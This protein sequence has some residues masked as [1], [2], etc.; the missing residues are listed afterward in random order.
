VGWTWIALTASIGLTMALA[1]WWDVAGLPALPGLAFAFL[2]PNGD[3]LWREFQ[4]WRK[5]RK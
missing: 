4:T 5:S 3:L 2:I 1:V